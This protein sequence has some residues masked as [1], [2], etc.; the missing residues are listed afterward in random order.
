MTIAP[1][2]PSLLSL[3][4]ASVMELSIVA[5]RLAW[6]KE[7]LD[8]DLCKSERTKALKHS[9]FEYELLFSYFL[10]YNSLEP[11]YWHRGSFHAGATRDVQSMGAL[12]PDK[13]A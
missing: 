10:S 1:G 5:G 2:A 12:Q 11:G 3:K 6:P 13:A 4:F 7:I 8:K 9:A